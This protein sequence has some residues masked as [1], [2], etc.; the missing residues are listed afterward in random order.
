MSREI[1]RWQVIPG[2]GEQ[3]LASVVDDVFLWQQ[4]GE[5]LDGLGKQSAMWQNNSDLV[6]KSLI[7]SAVATSTFDRVIEESDK[8]DDI[9]RN[10]IVRNVVAQAS[11]ERLSKLERGTALCDDKYS[12]RAK[13]TIHRPGVKFNYA[14]GDPITGYF[15]RSK[16]DAEEGEIFKGAIEY[17]STKPRQG[18]RIKLDRWSGSLV[19]HGLVDPVKADP[20]VSIEI[21][22]KTKD[23]SKI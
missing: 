6:V 15:W 10:S 14:F 7:D 23:L 11:F 1:P 13:I 12:Q 5:V 22:G 18:G 2:L 21:I 20:R 3:K 16:R 4:N 17:F 8:L 19:L 9:A